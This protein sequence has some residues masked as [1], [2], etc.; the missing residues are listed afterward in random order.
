[1]AMLNPYPSVGDDLPLAL[2]VR[3]VRDGRIAP[4]TCAACGCRLIPSKAGFVHFGAGTGVDGRGCRVACIDV[5]HAH[6]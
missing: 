3:P 4:V 5:P 1:M 6:D 2:A